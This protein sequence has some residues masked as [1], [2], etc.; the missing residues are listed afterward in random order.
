[1]AVQA[2]HDHYDEGVLHSLRP[3]PA[4]TLVD[5]VGK[6]AREIPENPALF[7]KGA[8]VSFAELERQSEAFGTALIEVGVKKGDRIAL[9][10]PN[11]PQ[12]IVGEFGIWK[13][14]AI[15]VPLNPLY[16]EQELEYALNEC[17]AETAVVLAPF[18]NRL[19]AVQAKTP[20]RLII[21]TGIKEY[22]T[23]VKKMLFTFLK[24]KKE[25][26][27]VRIDTGDLSFSGMIRQYM[28]AE[29]YQE[30]PD[31]DDP[32]LF[33]FS[34]GTTGQPKCAVSTHNSLV[35]TGMQ[36]SE[37][38][39]KALVREKDIFIL[40]MPLF[41]AYAQVGVMAT[42]FVGRYPMAV[43]PNP[44][45]VEDLLDTIKT[46]KPALLPG[47]P[48][49][50]NSLLQH[51]KVLAKKNSLSCLKICVSSAGPLTPKTRERIEELTGGRLINAY[52]LTE[53]TVASVIEP[54]FGPKKEGGT[55][56]PAPDVEVR[57][58]DDK[59]EKSEL[60]PGEVGEIVIRG[61]QLMKGY[62][63]RP[64]ENS[65]VL[66]EGWLYTGDLGYLD[67]E[68]YL[69]VVDRKKDVIKPSGFQV[70]P[71]EVE[72]VICSHPVV[73]EAGVA[74]VA[75]DYKGEAVKAWIVLKEGQQV[76]KRE[77]RAWCRRELAAFKVPKEIVFVDELPKSPIGKLLRRKLSEAD[78]AVTE[79][80]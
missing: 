42:G 77:L 53:A 5:I 13:A 19:K 1:M 11:S 7:F 73:Q 26:H 31:P 18:Y 35:M 10:M 52:S 68:G 50:F 12:M 67:K 56:I 74:G 65:V 49:F 9:L 72:K 70:W 76:T 34:G 30:R 59:D 27:R 32:A 25:G 37:W 21:A 16:T 36:F 48:T 4:R 15:V 44:R 29:Q 62:W 20:L 55:G 8:T 38:F 58:L 41:H 28:G 80:E 23:P 54:V 47:V 24:E 57:I 39:A 61:P 43:L 78:M 6:T 64:E 75:D 60:P 71:S 2:W 17:G 79:K 40:N 14:G 63:D 3:Y 69:Y 66:R 51:P 33:L 46:L 22:L 45:D